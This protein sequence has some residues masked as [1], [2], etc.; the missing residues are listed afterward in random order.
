MKPP[1]Q[2]PT[3]AESDPQQDAKR[4]LELLARW[5]KQRLDLGD[6]MRPHTMAGALKM[7]PWRIWNAMEYLKTIGILRVTYHATEHQKTTDA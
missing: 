4:V 6:K 7:S 3:R 5:E 2:Q 1:R